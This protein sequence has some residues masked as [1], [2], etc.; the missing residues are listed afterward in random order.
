[1]SVIYQRLTLSAPNPP[2]GFYIAPRQPA[3]GLL[4]QCPGK[5]MKCQDKTWQNNN[6]N[7]IRR[8]YSV[9]VA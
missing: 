8:T 3:A 5:R 1:M 6:V 2:A 7:T 4:Q 9:G